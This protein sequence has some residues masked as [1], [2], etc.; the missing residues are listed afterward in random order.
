MSLTELM[1]T[2]AE[3]PRAEKFRL[4]QFLVEDLARDEGAP[5]LVAG[6]EYPVWT[7]LDASEAAV[8]L[9]NLLAEPRLAQ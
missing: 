2:L 8:T 1:P 4:V 3:L 5:A 6:A 7:P 9:T